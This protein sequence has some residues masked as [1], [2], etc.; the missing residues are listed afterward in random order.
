VTERIY[1]NCPACGYSAYPHEI[2]GV[3]TKHFLPH[4]LECVRCGFRTETTMTWKGAQE[5]WNKE[6]PFTLAV[7]SEERHSG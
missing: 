7:P 4:S 3:E 2:L 5:E 1:G 6:R